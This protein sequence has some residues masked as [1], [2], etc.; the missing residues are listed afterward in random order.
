[1]AAA[2]VT[3]RVRTIVIC[4]DISGSVTE[5]GIFTLGGVWLHLAASSFPCRATLSLYLLLSSPRHGKYAR[6]VLVVH[7]QS[8]RTI[9]YL[10]F[11]ASFAEGDQLLLL[12]VPIGDCVFPEAGTYNFEVYFSARDGGEALKGEYP[13]NVFP[14]EE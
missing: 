9:R 11:V 14:R 3:L 10:N 6:K 7:E 12:Y 8:D 2:A 1:M 13:F 4:D 5:R